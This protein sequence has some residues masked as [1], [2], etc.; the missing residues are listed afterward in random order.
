MLCCVSKKNYL[1]FMLRKKCLI[2]GSTWG[3]F[4]QLFLVVSLAQAAT[5]KYPV[6]VANDLALTRHY[7]YV[8]EDSSLF[9]NGRVYDWA[10]KNHQRTLES[11]VLLLKAEIWLY[12]GYLD[13]VYEICQTVRENAQNTGNRSLL[14]SAML[15]QG[16]YFTEM[17]VFDKAYAE[18]SSAWQIALQL[19]DSTCLAHILNAFG[20]LYDL[21]KE[22]DLALDHYEKG[23]LYAKAENDALLR[24]RLLNN[25]AIIYTEQ[26]RVEEA[27]NLLFTCI[28]DI[29]NRR[30]AFGLDRLYMNLAPVYITAGDMD[31]A[32]INIKLSLEIA[33]KHNNFSSMARSLIYEGYIYFTLN[34]IQKAKTVFEQAD[35]L[36][37]ELGADNMHCMVLQYFVQ[38]AEAEQNHEQAYRYLQQFKQV[39]DSL[40]DRR[41]IVNLVRLKME[42]E[43]I[44]AELTNQYKF[45]RLILSTVILALVLVLGIVVFFYWYSRSRKL[46]EN[47]QKENVFLASELE[48]EN[49][50]MVTQSIRQKKQ[51]N[52]LQ[53]IA[54]QLQQS[55]MLFKTSNQPLIDRTI[56]LLKGQD[57]EQ[58][59]E[60]ESRFERVHISFLKNLQKQYPD[61]S[62]TE[63]RLCAFLRL[64]MTTKEIANIMHVSSRAVEQSRYRLRKKLGL[65]KKQDINTFLY[66]FD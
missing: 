2:K 56:A 28:R 11:E 49:K 27:K 62:P 26:E 32:L 20:V 8:N 15:L 35:S 45:Y 17:N 36:A 42:N 13:N 4:C 38:I 33:R 43:A 41:N 10:V 19:N 18:L 54:R 30:I 66:Q 23:L 63:K 60:F 46:L 55:R 47:K 39:S 58:W 21:Q 22:P 1:C 7:L 44:Q 40:A 6:S 16:R 34:D 5:P 61:L 25:K 37:L 24:I 51:T 57:D 9:F 53:E 52:D 59:Q 50:K 12:K 3:I 14:I 48:Q 29:R 64:N 31:S 65:K